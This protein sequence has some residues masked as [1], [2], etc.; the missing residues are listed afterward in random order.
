[1]RLK[2]QLLDSRRQAGSDHE[3]AEETV[4]TAE[5]GFQER[6]VENQAWQ[7]MINHA[8]TRV[9]DS[10]IEKNLSEEDHRIKSMAYPNAEKKVAGLQ[11]SLK[12]SIKKSREYFEV[13]EH[14]N[15]TLDDQKRQI[16]MIEE[17]IMMTKRGYA[18]SLKE[19]E[20]ISEE[21]HES[22]RRQRHLSL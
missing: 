8:T 19:L 21:I 6:G 2:T 22:R 9:N 15:Q 3:A 20:T 16:Q 17:T 11:K 10:E 14:L 12:R 18:D 4:M 13:K 7:E 1:M 5:E